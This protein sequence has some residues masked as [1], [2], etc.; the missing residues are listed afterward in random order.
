[1]GPFTGVSCRPR[2]SAGG[3]KRASAYEVF[4]SG[5]LGPP[6]RSGC[7]C[8]L[9]TAPVDALAAGALS[10][11]LKYQAERVVG[12]PRTTSIGRR[13]K[14]GGRLTRWPPLCPG[15]KLIYLCVWRVTDGNID[16]ARLVRAGAYP[17][18][19][20]RPHASLNRGVDVCRL[21]P[22]AAS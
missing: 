6:E 3:I 1:M 17:V 11:E 10:G 20:G 2:P 13:L 21:L 19:S 5:P 9:R 18:R 16:S 15:N 7:A 8:G 22:F 14:R 4:N 12:W